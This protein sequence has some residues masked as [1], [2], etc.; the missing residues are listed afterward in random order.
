MPG[1]P[2]NPRWWT[3][4]SFEGR[5][6][7]EALRERDIAFV[8]RFLRSRGLSRSMIAGYTG[9]AET[10]VRAIANRHQIVTAYGV[11]ER[12][13][14]GLAIPRSLMGL[15]TAAE[16]LPVRPADPANDH[17]AAPVLL[18]WLA[19][20][21][22]R[23]PETVLRD[24]G[25]SASTRPTGA[26]LT[27]ARSSIAEAL[28][29]YYRVDESS[30]LQPY[31]VT[32]PDRE[33]TLSIVTKPDWIGLSAA[34]GTAAEQAVLIP[35]SDPALVLDEVHY[36]AAAARVAEISRRGTRV[37]DAP[38]YRLLSVEPRPDRLRCEFAT[39]TFIEY[40]LT[41]DLLEPELIANLPD[42]R[43]RLPLRDRLLPDL[44][45]VADVANRICAGG[46]CTLFAAARPADGRR[47]RP[48]Y[49][50]LVQ[51][52]SEQVLNAVGRLSVIPKAFHEPLTDLAN[53]AKLSATLLREMEEELFGRTELDSADVDVKRFADP[54]HPSL[55]SEPL[56]W[57]VDRRDAGVWRMES[58]GVG[59]NLMSGN[60]EMACLIVIEDPAW[61]TLF[62]GMIQG[63]W[64]ADGLRIYSSLDT[65]LLHE[66]MADAAWSDEGLFACAEG[67]RRLRAIA[68]GPAGSP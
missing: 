55:L 12:I 18:Q 54:M 13:A 65:D 22:E 61:W 63:N 24:I 62:G 40:A 60:Y 59:L 36:A 5:P 6:L 14:E 35:R 3:E 64:E 44:A 27:P 37:V 23:D 57:L 45:K 46:V 19:R 33:L 42:A 2:I 4:E 1:Q 10:R 58:V 50:L 15:G 34:L 51:Q 52:R 26:A 66:L 8:F 28:L 47:D 29:A 17:S 68:A 16:E 11:L 56:R 7:T 41:M 31:R 30:A 32:L 43:R 21:S 38:V 20:R 49:A 53:D 9:L 25:R 67:L 39:T 48:D